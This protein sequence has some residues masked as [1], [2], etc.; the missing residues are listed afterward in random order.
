MRSE[1]IRLFTQGYI[2]AAFFTDGG[3]D[4]PE[5]G[6]TLDEDSQKHMSADCA[7]FVQTNY[8]L[9]SRAVDRVGYGWIEA[10]RDFW[11]TRN[12]HGVGY[13][14][15]NEL[16]G[17]LDQ[18]LTQACRH[19]EAFLFAGADVPPAVDW[20]LICS[21]CGLPDGMNLSSFKG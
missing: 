11:F 9:L 18:Q 1:N 3:P 16:R 15:R 5:L 10:G 20:T 17:G 7:A 13:W 21:S 2:E 6:D 19:H 4:H 12:G 8:E 14:S